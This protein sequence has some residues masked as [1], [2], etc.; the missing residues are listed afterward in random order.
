MSSTADDL[1]FDDGGITLRSILIN[2]KLLLAVLLSTLSLQSFAFGT[3][4]TS[5]AQRALLD[6]RRQNNE[7]KSLPVQRVKAVVHNETISLEGLVIRQQGPAT[8]WLNGQLFDQYATGLSLHG[9]PEGA[10]AVRLPSKQGSVL[11]KPGQLIRP[12]SGELR[13]AYQQQRRPLG[14][15]QVVPSETEHAPENLPHTLDID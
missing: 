11:L 9:E 5:P 14:G 4:L 2:H 12:E 15:N 6:N 8:I 3:L 7:L 10:T 1:E 13:D